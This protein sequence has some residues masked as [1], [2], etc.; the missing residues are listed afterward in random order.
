MH[1]VHAANVADY[2][3]KTSRV[4][5]QERVEAR[6]LAGGVSNIVL[7]MTLPSR[8]E[9]FVLKQAR[10][11]LRVKDDWRCPVERIWR[12]V[13]TLRACRQLIERE[14]GDRPNGIQA[15]VP[16]ILWEDREN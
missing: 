10:G 12:E 15:V 16:E 11:Q 8:G 6:E 1:E 13:D 5:P 14:P 7:L 4:G 3:R 9:Q 2:L